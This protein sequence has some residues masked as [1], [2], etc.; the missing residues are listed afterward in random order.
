MRF[1]WL[2][3]AVLAAALAWAPAWAATGLAKKVESPISEPGAVEL[4][5]RGGGYSGANRARVGKVEASRGLAENWRIAFLGEFE[6]EPGRD[7]RF[8]S[9]AFETVIGFGHALGFDTGIYLEY[10]QRLHNESGVLEGKFLLERKF[11]G[12]KTRANFNAE[13]PLTK[14]DGEGALEFGYAGLALVE[15]IEHIEVGLE[16][17]GDLGTSRHFGG[18]NAHFLGPAIRW[19][20]GEGEEAMGEL[21]LGVSYLFNVGDRSGSAPGALNFIVE[22]GAKF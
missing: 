13:Q 6:K 9:L 11:G 21:E 17:H 15:A 8:D 14:K 1:P 20:T 5:V 12:L 3:M 19:E 16:A 7:T 4:E 22:W 10:E 2:P 18:R